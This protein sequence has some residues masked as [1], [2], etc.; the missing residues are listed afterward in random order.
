MGLDP[1]QKKSI[2]I[3]KA[4]INPQKKIKKIKAPAFKKKYRAINIYK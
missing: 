3:Y 2:Y 4:L 1:G